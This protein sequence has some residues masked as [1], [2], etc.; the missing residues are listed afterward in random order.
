MR[1]NASSYSQLFRRLRESWQPAIEKATSILRVQAKYR[2]ESAAESFAELLE[3]LLG[4]QFEERI[5]R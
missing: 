5:S 2:R 1:K 3:D 4:M